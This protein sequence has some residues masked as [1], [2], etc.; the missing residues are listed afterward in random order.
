M[1]FQL[2]KIRTIIFQD[3][4]YHMPK[5]KDTKMPKNLNFL[6]K[7]PPHDDIFNNYYLTFLTFKV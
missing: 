1:A 5:L 7:I 4:E 6:E 3:I 2:E